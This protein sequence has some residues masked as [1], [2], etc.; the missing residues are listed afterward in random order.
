MNAHTPAPRGHAAA[1]P[2]DPLDDT[3]SLESPKTDLGRCIGSRLEAH[4]DPFTW[5]F[6]G[7]IVGGSGALVVVCRDLVAKNFISLPGGQR[8][9]ILNWVEIIARRVGYLLALTHKHVSL[10]GPEAALGGCADMLLRRGNQEAR[11]PPPHRF[12]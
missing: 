6:E 5:K 11:R 3:L 10:V 7:R 8:G 4:V 2:R 1:S 9:G 12:S